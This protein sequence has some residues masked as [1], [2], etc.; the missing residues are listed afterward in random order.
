MVVNNAM[1][2]NSR[3]HPEMKVP[4]LTSGSIVDFEDHIRKKVTQELLLLSGGIYG[5]H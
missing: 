5:L 1:V 4:E 3:H 2:P